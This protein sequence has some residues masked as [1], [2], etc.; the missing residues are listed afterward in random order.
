MDSYNKIQSLF[1]LVNSQENWFIND[2]SPSVIRY[3]EFDLSIKQIIAIDNLTRAVL[4]CAELLDA[5]RSDLEKKEN[6][7]G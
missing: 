4:V 2:K 3:S 5:I 1:E 7:N 6:N